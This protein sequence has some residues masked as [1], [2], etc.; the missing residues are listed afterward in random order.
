MA[1]TPAR[2]K[3][4]AA[5]EARPAA[6]GPALPKNP[7]KI[8]S[9]A[10]MLSRA[11]R[12]LV[13]SSLGKKLTSLSEKELKQFTSRA[14]A[15]HDKWRDL[16]R[17]QSRSTKAADRAK[18]DA[19]NARTSDKLAVMADALG[20]FEAQL[21]KITSSVVETVSKAVAGAPA[22]KA[23][24][25]APAATRTV[26][27]AAKKAAKKSTASKKARAQRSARAAAAADTAAA[28]AEA[29]SSRATKAKVRKAVAA[30]PGQAIRFDAAGQRKA[31]T[32]AKEARFKFEGL[33]NRRNQHAAANTRRNQAR[34]DSR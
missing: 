20:R 6:T 2:S 4:A 27:K 14:R 33:A 24:A 25:P 30:D 22:V 12:D 9:F 26:K 28:A 11:E 8:K 3:A 29:L 32:A 34:R 15:L 10:E 5:R 31:T 18:A 13:E 17:S 23:K 7:L 19:A 21:G 1:K 16:L